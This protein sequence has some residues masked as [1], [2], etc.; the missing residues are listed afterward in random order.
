M[1]Y[2]NLGRIVA[3]LT[4]I[5]GILVFAMGL[6]VA[7]GVIVEPEPGRYLGS[8]SPREAIDRGLLY[9][10]F[11]II[12]GILTEISRSLRAGEK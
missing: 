1:L 10:L 2:T 5:C 6:G 3:A 9:A 7:T 12:L 8:T 4:L 11:G